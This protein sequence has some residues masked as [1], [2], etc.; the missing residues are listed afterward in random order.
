[1]RTLFFGAGPLSCLYTHL[2]SQ[3][4][5]DV[6]ILARG[7]RYDWIKANGLVL[8]N[9]LTG[10]R[11][12]SNVKVV[13]RLRPDDEYDLV[14]VLMRKNKLPTV[15]QVLAANHNIKNILFMGNNALG[16]G[17]YMQYLPEER[18]LFGF[19]GAGGGVREHVVHYADREKP[20]G[21]R[22]AITI[23]EIDGKTRERTRVI[24]SLFE[25]SEIPVELTRDIDGW[26]K[27]HVALVSPLANALY[28]H[29]CDNYTLARDKGTIRMMVQAAKEGGRVLKAL[30]HTRRQPVKFNLFYWLPEILSVKAVQ[31]LLES[32]FAEI[33]F[34]LHA[35]AAQDEMKDLA[36]E[37]QILI[38][39][40]YIETPNINT[41]KGYVA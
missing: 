33:A 11:E 23:G 2:L 9:E 37:F 29:N 38:E 20:R 8:V 27:Y 39:K 21:K 4:G 36:D 24:K 3:T 5:K 30:G 16:F 34:A 25:T 14:V 41:L 12:T 31:G 7:P 6:K 15:F 35:R 13:D 22:R 28:K 18:L 19:P 17:Q 40:T 10:A 26:L 1:M 32:K